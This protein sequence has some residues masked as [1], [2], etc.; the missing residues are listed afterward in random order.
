[1][2]RR[3]ISSRHFELRWQLQRRQK[4]E[5][6]GL[7]EPEQFLE[8]ETTKDLHEVVP[9]PIELCRCHEFVVLYA[10]HFTNQ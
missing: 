9:Q 5:E 4:S 8:I 2:S 1:M 7:L 10:R 6:V 3:A